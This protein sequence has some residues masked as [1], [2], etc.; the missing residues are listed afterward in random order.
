MKS[1]YTRLKV[2]QVKSDYIANFFSDWDKVVQQQLNSGVT[3][4]PKVKNAFRFIG[5]D[6]SCLS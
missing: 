4:Q 6:E 3:T 1:N 5:K 2:F